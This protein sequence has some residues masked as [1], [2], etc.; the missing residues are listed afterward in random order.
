MANLV[1]SAVPQVVQG[2]MPTPA[3][4][5]IMPEFTEG[6]TLGPGTVRARVSQRPV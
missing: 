3:D 6:E 4:C 2:R 5:H 1:G